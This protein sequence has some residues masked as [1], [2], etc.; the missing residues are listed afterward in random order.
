MLFQYV[1]YLDMPMSFKSA[2]IEE[3]T[4]AERDQFA[5]I[6]E[7]FP[8]CKVF[9]VAGDAGEAGRVVAAA[10]VIGEDDAGPAEESMFPMMH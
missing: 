3:V 2:S 10:C 6:L 4:S 9:R 8:D 5:E 7:R 1:Q